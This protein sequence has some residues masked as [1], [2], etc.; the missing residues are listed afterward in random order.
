MNYVIGF[1]NKYYT[2]WSYNTVTNYITISDKRLPS[3]KTTQYTYIKNISINIETVKRLYPNVSIDEGLRGK[4]RNFVVTE[5]IFP[6]NVLNFGKYAGTSI[7]DLFELDFSYIQWLHSNSS[8]RGYIE[9]HPK[10]IKYQNELA[11]I[12]RS[13]NEMM[14]SFPT[15]PGCLRFIDNGYVDKFAELYDGD[16]ISDDLNCVYKVYD[17]YKFSL[18]R[19]TPVLMLRDSSDVHNVKIVI[20]QNYKRVNGK[21][22]YNMA[23]IGNKYVKMK[24]NELSSNLVPISRFWNTES[25]ITYYLYTNN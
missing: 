25:S 6:D 7:D 9:E 14:S 19:N 23:L 24:N 15:E 5:N 11:N 2:L 16:W 12:V 1:T 8:K 10:W 18:L 4:K 20:F 22:P 3:T 21:Y 17:F 13:R